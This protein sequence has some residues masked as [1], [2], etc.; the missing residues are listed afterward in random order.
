[1]LDLIRHC[2]QVLFYCHF[3]DKLLSKRT[4]LLKRL[5]RIPFDWIEQFTTGMSDRV[6]VNS[7][8]TAG[9]YNEV[10]SRIQD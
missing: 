10:T 8:F 4:T 2:S 7:Q 6:L 9:V 3:P 1:M 5:Y